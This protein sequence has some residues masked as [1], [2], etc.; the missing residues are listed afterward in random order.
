LLELVG[1]VLVLVPALYYSVYGLMIKRLAM[2][3]PNWSRDKAFT[4]FVSVIIPTFNERRT[5]QERVR[6]LEQLEYPTS[7][8]EVIFVDGASNDGTPQIIG[9]LGIG[10]PFVHL[11]QQ[12]TREGYNSAVYEGICKA[13]SSLIVMA[14]AGS[15]FHPGAI[16]AIIR[17]LADPSIGAATGKAVFHNPSESLATRLEAAFRSNNDQL[18]IAESN[19]DSTVDMKGELLAFRKDIGL[20]LRPRENLPD[21]AAFD[22]SIG[23]MSRSLG[24]R[25]VFDPEAMFYEY[26]P[27]TIRERFKVQLTRGTTFTGALWRFRTMV[28]NRK[29]GS[30]GLIILPSRFLMLIVFPWMLLAAPFVL[31]W[32]AMV[33]PMVAPIALA[34]MGLVGL[35]LLH[36]KTRIAFLS[37][38]LSQFILVIVTLRLLLKRHTHFIHTAQTTRR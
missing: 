6:N 32:E 37:F 8:L 10:R 23:Y 35:L 13:S 22:T 15:M 34:L 29:F 5:I 14:D 2:R 24:Y 33:Q 26:A 3:L 19:I 17:N 27:S 12:P 36:P 21:T 30:Y 25:A 31:I 38:S 16:S 11:L 4:P 7:S 9:Q 18:R 28:L 1:I 20:R